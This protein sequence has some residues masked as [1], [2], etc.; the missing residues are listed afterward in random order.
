MK[1]SATVI[2]KRTIVIV[3]KQISPKLTKEQ[4]WETFHA[5]DADEVIFDWS[6]SKNGYITRDEVQTFIEEEVAR[7]LDAEEKK[8]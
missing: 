5:T 8:R 6:Y 4:I 1:T 3:V 7:I 2:T